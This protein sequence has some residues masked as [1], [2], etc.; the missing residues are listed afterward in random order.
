MEEKMTR[1]IVLR[2]LKEGLPELRERYGV[3][4]IALHGSF[5]RNRQTG[6]SDVDLLV[7]LAKPLGFAFVELAEC[8][9]EIVGRRVELATFETY[10][11]SKEDARR[12]H[13][14]VNIEKDLVY[15]G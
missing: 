1:E 7:E 15:V 11:R 4:R 14:A 3:R 13:I 9:E 6:R 2:R 8:L 12:R 5:A 10:G